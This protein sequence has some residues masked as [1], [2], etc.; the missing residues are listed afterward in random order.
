MVMFGPE[1]EGVAPIIDPDII[2]DEEPIVSL[3][4]E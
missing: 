1:E 2:A 4:P 3:E